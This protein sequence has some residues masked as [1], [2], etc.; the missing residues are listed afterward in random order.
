MDRFH[1][2]LIAGIIA[3]VIMNVWSFISYYL[4][5]FTTRKY[6]DWTGVILY[7]DLPRN[8]GETIY[9]LLIHLVW[10]GLLGVIFAYI[11]PRITSRG[12]L[13]KGVF[14]GF[15]T[16]FITYAITTL[17]KTPHITIT[18]LRTVISDHIG[19]VIFGLVLAQMLYWL[20]DT[21]VRTK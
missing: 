19:G 7:G 12:Y 18:P 10:T 3:G 16:G 2:G 14:F 21:R 1:R 15:V 17:F 9:A 6:V 20:D 8:I 13:I 5:Q 4:L 11:L